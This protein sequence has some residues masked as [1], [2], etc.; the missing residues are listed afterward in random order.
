MQASFRSIEYRVRLA[1]VKS[2]VSSGVY[3]VRLLLCI[4]SKMSSNVQSK[5][6]SGVYRVRF[7]PVYIEQGLLLCIQS[8]DSSSIYRVRLASVHTE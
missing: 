6:S 8:R 2:K 3:R 4:Q 7:A 5:V 1:S